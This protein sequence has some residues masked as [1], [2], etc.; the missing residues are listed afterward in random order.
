MDPQP[1]Q[2]TDEQAVAPDGAS[3]SDV[4]QEAESGFMN[5]MIR[6]LRGVIGLESDDAPSD[7]AEETGAEE[8]PTP[9]A[10]VRP[11][12][13]AMALDP[14]QT[15]EFRAAVQSAKDR[16][17]TRERRDWAK[18]RADQ[19]DLEPIRQL[20]EKGDPWA[21]RALADNGD[22]WALGEIKQRELREA[23][24]RENDPLPILA[25]GFDQ[26]VLWPLLGALPKEEEERIVGQGIQGFD[27]R[28]KAVTDAVASLRRHAGEEALAKALDSEDFVRK[29]LASETFRAA[30]L[31][32]PTVGKQ[33]LARHRGEWDEP[34]LA[35]GS[36]PGRGGQRENDVMNNALRDALRG[37]TVRADGERAAVAAGRRNGLS[38]GELLTDE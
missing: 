32:H 26:S 5:R 19:G 8:Q 12:P 34:D 11:S 36:G 37:A 1:A 10:A 21:Q 27:G 30:I 35:P 22:T 25:S 28:Q 16:E 4:A 2:P 14:T 3:P 9:D 17:L 13:A 29:A 15:P 24:A 31:S 20:A 6:G 23:Q 7:R 33:L 18:T 38:T